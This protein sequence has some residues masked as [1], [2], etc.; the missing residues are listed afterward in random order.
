M[1]LQS[2]QGF[3]HPEPASSGD[4]KPT[5]LLVANQ[6]PPHVGGAPKVYERLLSYLPGHLR[7][8]APSLDY[9]TGQ[10]LTGCEAFDQR[11]PDRIC[12]LPRL[13]PP[14]GPAPR[15][16]LEL[17]IR[18]WKHDLPVRRQVWERVQHL[19]ERWKPDVVC[20]GDLY[21]SAWL[22]Q[23]LESTGIPTLFYV[24]GDEISCWTSSRLL[25]WETTRALRRASGA[26]AVSSY[27]REF[28]IHRGAY[29][30]HNRGTRTRNS[31]QKRFT[32]PEP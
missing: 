20:L 11:F 16:A 9:Q 28:L 24:H 23:K 3:P 10:P 22:A 6:F 7:V 27:A 21:T 13:R 25:A 26:V 19:V 17:P 15:T 29:R 4:P 31:R 30:R 12:R 5:V 1:T 8:L 18:W 14:A 2:L 32:A